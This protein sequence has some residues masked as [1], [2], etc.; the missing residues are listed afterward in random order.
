MPGRAARHEAALSGLIDEARRNGESR[1]AARKHHLVPEF[2]LKHWADDGKIRVTNVDEG[3]SWVTTPNKAAFET[4]YYR[5][6]SPEIDPQEVPPL[7]FETALSKIE[8]WGAEYIKALIVDPNTKIDDEQRVL[9][10]L[11]MAMQYVRGRH[12]RAVAR[13]S[14]TDYFKLKYGQLTQRGMRNLLQ[15]RGL[16]VND[17]NI[18]RIRRFSNDLDS[19]D[20]TLG[21]SKASLLGISGQMVSNIGRYLFERGWHVYLVPPILVTCDEPVIPVPGPPHP[22]S[23][24]GGVAD[25]GVVL[26]PLTPSL[27]LAMFDDENASPRRPYT[28]GHA[29]L[30]EINREIVGASSAYAF[31]RPSRRTAAA[32]EVPNDGA[33][34]IS[35]VVLSENP[36][37]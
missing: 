36:H 24:R 26:F 34:R 2:Y 10:S 8:Q 33:H 14:A 27:L 28:L 21:P 15:E 31:E 12:F 7:L 32:L 3:K 1:S 23:E 9:F 37:L 17:E 30:A 16:E 4:D 35:P 22:R 18:A 25:A 19:G 6:D 13:A 11:Y 29:D 5:I 20:F